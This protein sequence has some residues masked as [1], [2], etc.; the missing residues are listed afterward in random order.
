MRH[1][2]SQEYKPPYYRNLTKDSVAT[3]KIT[4]KEGQVYGLSYTN[5][6]EA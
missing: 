1:E 5:R 2:L 3:K 4:A 6:S